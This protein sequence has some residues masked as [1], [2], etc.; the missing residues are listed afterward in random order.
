MCGGGGGGVLKTALEQIRAFWLSRQEF[1]EELK[2]NSH[3]SLL[4]ADNGD[5]ESLQLSTR[6]VLHICCL[7][8]HEI[9]NSNSTKILNL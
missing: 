9:C 4:D 1:L 5:G 7:H 6:Q 8:I 2:L 3:V